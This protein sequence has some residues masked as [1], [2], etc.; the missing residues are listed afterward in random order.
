MR[1]SSARSGIAS[2]GGTG[3][4]VPRVGTCGAGSQQQALGS[5]SDGAPLEGQR[6]LEVGPFEGDA[7]RCEHVFHR[8]VEQRAQTLDDL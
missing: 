6:P 7:V 4:T 1:V 8:Q 3:S 5:L 2:T